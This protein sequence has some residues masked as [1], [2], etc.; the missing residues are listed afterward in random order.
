MR[1]QSGQA[2]TEYMVAAVFLMIIVWYAL[3]GGDLWSTEPD[4]VTGTMLDRQHSP[5]TAAPG[6]VQALH[7]KQSD[8][9]NS[10]YEP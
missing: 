6:L 3:V 9:A 7:K 10:I 4:P 2:L 5:S 8:F 1:S